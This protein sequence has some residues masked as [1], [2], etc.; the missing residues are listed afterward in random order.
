MIATATISQGSFEE[1]QYLQD[2]Q[3]LA[4]PII[5]RRFRYILLPKPKVERLIGSKYCLS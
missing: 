2:S 5:W 4:T 3:K 1:Y